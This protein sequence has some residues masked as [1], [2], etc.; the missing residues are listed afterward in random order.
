MGSPVLYFF[1]L[2]LKVP[3]NLTPN[4]IHKGSRFSQTFL[5]K[6][7]KFFPYKGG[8]PILFDTDLI[9]LPAEVDPIPEKRDCKR[10]AFIAFGFSSFEMVLALLIEIIAFYMQV[11]KVQ[12]EV[13]GFEKPV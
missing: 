2:V 5:E 13:P 3:L 10:D 6:S 11:P 4:I 7:L 12:L 8:G 1:L 9:L